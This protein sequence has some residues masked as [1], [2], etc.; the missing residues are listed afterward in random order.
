M[1]APLI[2]TH[3]A[4]V[5]ALIASGGNVAAAAGALG[6]SRQS[7]T[8]R[9]GK[10]A[11]LRKAVLQARKAA[12]PT[13]CGACGGSGIITPTPTVPSLPRQ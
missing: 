11:A 9:I 4:A 3:E 13:V 7:L 12:K 1:S 2:V 10:S 5:R 8:E 6:V